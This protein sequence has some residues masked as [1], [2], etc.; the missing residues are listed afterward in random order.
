MHGKTKF[1]TILACEGSIHSP[2]TTTRLHTTTPTTIQ[3]HTTTP[4][5]TTTIRLHTTTTPTTT[6]TILLLLYS[7]YSTKLLLYHYTTTTTT[8]RSSHT[9]KSKLELSVTISAR[10]LPVTCFPSITSVYMVKP[11]VVSHSDNCT[12]FLSQKA[13]P[14]GLEYTRWNLIIHTLHSCDT[15]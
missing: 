2:T 3:L 14:R 5:T 1:S 11:M 13:T 6:T 7:Y 8:S 15:I 10:V 12:Q 4:T 9:N